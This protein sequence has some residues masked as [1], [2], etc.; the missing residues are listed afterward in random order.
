MVERLAGIAINAEPRDNPYLA[1]ELA[2]LFKA[3]LSREM[4]AQELLYYQS[5]YAVNLLRSGQNERAAQEFAA[6]QK[7]LHQHA[8]EHFQRLL[9]NIGVLMGV[10]Y[11]R[12]GE[13]ENCRQNHSID[14]CLLPI[15]GKGVHEL[16]RGSRAAKQIFTKL[17]ARF[18]ENTSARWLLNIAHM[19]LGEYPQEVNSR[20]QLPPAVFESEFSIPRFSDVAGPLGLDVD[21]LCGG[22]VLDDFD[23]DKDYDLVVTSFGLRDPIRYFRN[24]GNGTFSEQTKDAGLTGIYGGLNLIHADYNNDG[25]LDLF[26]LRGGWFGLAGEHPNSLLRNNGDGTFTDI[27][28]VA[29]LLSFHPTQTATWLDFDNDGWLDLFVGN[30]STDDSNHPCELFHN[31]RDGTFTD[32]ARKSGVAIKRFVKGVVS[33]DYDNDGRVDLY[34]SCLG[35]PN[36]LFRNLSSKD[37]EGIQWH[38]KDVAE[39]AGVVEPTDSF[40]T[41]F[42]DY[43]NDGWLD[44]FVAGYRLTQVGDMALDYLGQA[45]ESETARLYRN[46]GDGT[47]EDVSVETGFH[48]L[49]HAMGVN[50]GDLDNDGF[51]DCYIGTGDSSL[52]SLMPNRM[53]RN[54]GGKRFQ[55]VT[56][57]GGFGHL[58][59]GHGVSFGDLDH[60]GDQDVHIVMGGAY[61]SDNYRNALFENPGSDNHWLKLD[62]KGTTSNRSA[63]GARIKVVVETDNGHRDIHRVVS[64]GGSFGGNPFRR[65]IGL[66]NAHAIQ[67][68]EVRWPATG[69]VQ[70]WTNLELD[71]FYILSEGVE[72]P[73]VNQLAPVAWSKTP[74]R[75]NHIHSDN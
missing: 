4:T 31:N 42:W 68:V 5:Q 40:P 44:I 22:S 21:A 32:V 35:Q 34:L 51:L 72:R 25:Y 52:A 58:Q 26:V 18:P 49:L 69:L 62:I 74:N 70:K 66:G 33:G 59:K 29:G 17:L 61:P 16:P 28:E 75:S 64:S 43:D 46:N 23:G 27:T 14:S 60:D 15:E 3:A 2:E 13:F 24:D 54:A 7:V 20:W 19:T 39:Q 8:P 50:Y 1:S 65:E 63:I 67:L 56:T 37:P 48:R 45:H 71:Q 9:P 53:F 36:I 11:L 6:Y 30:E 55:D 73:D 12:I 10:C 41:W 57:A 47:F 38:F